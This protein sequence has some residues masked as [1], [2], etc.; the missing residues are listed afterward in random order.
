MSRNLP[1]GQHRDFVGSKCQGGLSERFHRAVLPPG[2]HLLKRVRRVGVCLISAS[3]I[4]SQGVI[5]RV[6]L[7]FSR[8]V[9]V[10]TVPP[11]GLPPLALF[12]SSH[13]CVSVSLHFSLSIFLSRHLTRYSAFPVPSPCAMASKTT[14]VVSSLPVM[15]FS[16]CLWA[17]SE[18]LLVF[19]ERDLSI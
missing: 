19:S 15:C 17:F 1:G 16:E 9:F 3:P 8:C 14:R 2:T 13:F 10:Y 4:G 11:K 12:L 18:F 6:C 7:N 5:L